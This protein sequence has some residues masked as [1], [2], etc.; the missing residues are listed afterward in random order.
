MLDTHKNTKKI[1]SYV[2][3]KTIT[4]LNREERI[5]KTLSY[6]HDSLLQQHVQWMYNAF[7]FDHSRSFRVNQETL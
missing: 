2:Y 7:T 5:S 3:F 6:I 4:C 1:Y